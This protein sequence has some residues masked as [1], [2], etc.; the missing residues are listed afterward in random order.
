MITILLLAACWLALM[1]WVFGQGG[2]QHKNLRGVANYYDRDLKVFV[3]LKECEDCH[4]TMIT[5]ER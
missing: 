3:H 1:V 2:C 4:L 5:H